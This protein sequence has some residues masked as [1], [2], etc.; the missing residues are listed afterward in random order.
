MTK[1]LPAMQEIQ[2]QSL[3][4]EDPLETKMETHCSILAWQILWT[5]EPGGLQTMGSQ[6]AGHDWAT[7]IFTFTHLQCCVCE[8]QLNF[9]KTSSHLCPLICHK[10][11]FNSCSRLWWPSR[12]L[13]F[14]LLFHLLYFVVWGFPGG[15]DGKESACDV[16]GPGLALPLKK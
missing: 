15:S 5:E 4:R 13:F 12:V 7:I 8:F 14:N 16:G 10:W 6:R 2:V 3:G 9:L 11:L 1:N